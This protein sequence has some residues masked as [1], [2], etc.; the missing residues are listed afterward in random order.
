VEAFQV[1][2][3]R[4]IVEANSLAAAGRQ[5]AA[6]ELRA[7]AAAVGENEAAFLQSKGLEHSMAG[8]LGRAIEPLVRPLGF[9]WKIGVGIISSFAAREVIV[10]TLSV[11]YGVGEGGE[12]NESSLYDAL[13]ASTWEDGTPVFTW[14]ACLS[15][16]VFYILAM[17]CLPTQVVTYRET[18]TWK[19]P[20]FQFVYMSILAYS[21]AWI[22]YQL[23]SLFFSIT[24]GMI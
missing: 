4:L 7:E 3:D 21:A 6:E 9:D 15:L 12:A 16:L 19:W 10:S 20:L 5:A 23:S 22:T 14:P 24:G 11:L 13:R 17:Q 8:N 18:G 1:E 2:A